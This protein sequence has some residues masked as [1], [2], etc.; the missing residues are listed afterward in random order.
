MMQENPVEEVKEEVAIPQSIPIAVIQAPPNLTNVTASQTSPSKQ[1][2][3]NTTISVEPSKQIE[4]LEAPPAQEAKLQSAQA[5]DIAQKNKQSVNALEPVNMAD[6]LKNQSNPPQEDNNTSSIPPKHLDVSLIR[7][8]DTPLSQDKLLES[9]SH[10]LPEM[11]KT[12]QKMGSNVGSKSQQLQ[13]QKKFIVTNPKDQEIIKNLIKKVQDLEAKCTEL[14]DFGESTAVNLKG[15]KD[16]I[17]DLSQAMDKKA[18]ILDIKK[19]NSA[20]DE[21]NEIVKGLKKE[22]EE[23]KTTIKKLEDNE[24]LRC[25]KLKHNSLDGKFQIALKNIKELEQ[26]V[27]ESMGTQIVPQSTGVEEEKVEEIIRKHTGETNEKINSLKI[28]VQTIQKDFTALSDS[29]DSKVEGKATVENL[30][31]LESMLLL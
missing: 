16:K 9:P 26:K 11:S 6:P 5:K 30:V 29:V 13:Y 19:I 10:Q 3:D 2:I 7:I 8:T 17:T 27:L 28:V 24:D 12:S 31:E 20:I 14:K 18:T 25:L 1:Q 4:I 23:M 15:A 22:I 21:T